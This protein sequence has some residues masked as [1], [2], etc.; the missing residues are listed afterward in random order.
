MN[1]GFK[2][3]A[4]DD[5]EEASGAGPDKVNDEPV[6]LATFYDPV[7]AEIVLAKLRSAGI[8]CFSRHEALSVVMG[9]TVDGAGKQEIMVLPSDLAAARAA[10]EISADEPAN[11]DESVTPDQ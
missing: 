8:P 6:V 2:E 3:S 10:L 5:S 7:E 11:P 9:L 4:S 1:F